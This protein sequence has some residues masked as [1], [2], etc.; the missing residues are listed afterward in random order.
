ME[1]GSRLIQH[2]KAICIRMCMCV[3]ILYKLLCG[4]VKN[5][6]NVASIRINQTLL[7]RYRN[8]HLFVFSY[9]TYHIN[10]NFLLNLHELSLSHCAYCY[11]TIVEKK[12]TK[13]L[14]LIYIMIINRCIWNRTR[15]KSKAKQ[16]EKRK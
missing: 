13:I 4:T 5:H 6:Q 1:N 8:C 14:S 15:A 3:H 16:K 2:S 7:L 10:L 9:R 11:C 12:I